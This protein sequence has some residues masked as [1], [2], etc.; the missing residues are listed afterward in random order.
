MVEVTVGVWIAARNESVFALLSDVAGAA[1]RIKGIS[2]VEL[3]TPGPVGIGTRFRETRK[4]FGREA[5]ETMEFVAFDPP[6]GYTLHAESC[7]SRYTTT[8][9]CTP[10]DGGTQVTATFLAQPVSLV[11]RLLQPLMRSMMGTMTKCLRED[12]EDIKRAAETE[13]VRV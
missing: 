4:M 7:G 5:S 6:R 10:A 8:F 13:A 1:E 11:A 2:H 3:L 9:H 12:L